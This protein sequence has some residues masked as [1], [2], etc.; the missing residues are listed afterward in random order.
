MRRRSLA[1]SPRSVSGQPTTCPARSTATAS[2]IQ[3]PTAIINGYVVEPGRHCSTTSRSSARS[4][5]PPYTAG[6]AII[7]GHTVEEGVLG[8]GMCSSSTTLFNAAMRAG[9]DMQARRNH[10][11]YISRY[12]VGLDATVWIA[13]PHS[14]QTMSF[15]NDTAVPDPD[16]GHQPA[17]QGHVRDLRGARWAHGSALRSDHHQRPDRADLLRVHRLTARGPED[18]PG[19]HR[20]RLR[21][22]RHAHGQGRV[23]QRHPLGHVGVELQDDQRPD[24]GR[25]VSRRSAVWHAGP[26]GDLE[27]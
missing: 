2:N 4:R 5:R 27:G 14:Q 11:Y 10:T 15:V 25:T 21:L 18:A 3:I 17:Q 8:G 7:H 22:E 9:L 6:A 1:R 12:P 23:R 20:R 26:R 16:Q 24:P 19:V 13:G